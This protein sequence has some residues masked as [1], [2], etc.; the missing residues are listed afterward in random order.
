MLDNTF[1]IIVSRE[2]EIDFDERFI[3]Y[4]EQKDN[5]DFEF[6]EAFEIR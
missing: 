1:V 2:A 4:E 3:W 5:L 6:I